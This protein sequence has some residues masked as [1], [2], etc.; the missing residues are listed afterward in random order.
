[1]QRWFDRFQ[2]SLDDYI[3]LFEDLHARHQNKSRVKI[4]LAPA[5]LHWCSDAVLGRLAETSA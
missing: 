3:A 5:N 4:Q 2:L 1:M